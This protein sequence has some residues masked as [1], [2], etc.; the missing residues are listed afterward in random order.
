MSKFSQKR[1]L[2]PLAIAAFVSGCIS[3]DSGSE[4]GTEVD[5]TNP[6]D[7][8]T[9]VCNPLNDDNDGQGPRDQGLTAELFYLEDGVAL[10]SRVADMFDRGVQVEDI[11][12][13]FNRVHIPTR[14]WDRGF[15]TVS[16]QTVQTNDGDTLYEYFAV[17]MSG[18]FQLGN[19]P[20]GAYQFALLSDDGAVMSMDFGN[21][22]YETVVDNDG[23]HPTRFG[24]G[25]YPVVIEEGDKIPFQIEYYQGPRYHIALSLMVRPWVDDGSDSECGRQGNSRFFDSTQDPVVAQPAYDGL[26]ARGWAPVE[27]ESF[28]IPEELVENPCNEA[29]PV[30]SNFSVVSA[31]S[32]TVTLQWTTDIPASSQIYF[33]LQDV[34][35]YEIGADVPAL[36]TNHQVVLP[37]PLGAGLT[38]NTNYE[39]FARSA[40]SSG[41]SS[42][43]NVLIVRTR[44]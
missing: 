28:L 2:L 19:L 15:V 10:P 21:G 41:L 33:R 4:S 27:P 17:R 34:G 25:S 26:L 20:A 39:M 16:G 23:T 31:G 9:Y 40:S 30:I 3:P 32:D 7:P 43:S 36:V 11:L 29:A 14:P 8:S 42:D 37:T 18:R 13:Y 6:P 5:V 35:S 44:R 38:A 24:C 1:L 22:G 12:L